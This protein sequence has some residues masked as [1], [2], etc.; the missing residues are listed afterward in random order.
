MSPNNIKVRI[1]PSPSGYLHVGTAR[2]AIFNWLYA[3]QHG[4]KFIVRIEDTD[5][6]RSDANLVQPILEALKWLGIDWDEGPYYQSER[7]ERY[8]AYVAKLL[9]SGRA[10]RCFCT[11]EELERERAEAMAKKMAPRYDRKCLKK[12]DAEIS[13]LLGKNMPFAIRLKIPQGETSYDDIVLGNITRQNSEIEDLVICRADGRVVYNMAV[14]VD[15]YEMG[16]THVIRGNDH[17]TNTFKQIHI[18]R[19]LGI[20]LP[21]FAHLPL[22]LRSDR[23]K[24]SK[25]LGDK[26]VSEYGKEG[27]LP[28]ALFNFLCLLGWSPKD[29][30]EFLSK[31]ELIRVFK[32]ENVNPANPIFNEEKLVAL[33]KEYIKEYQ[34]YKLAE[35]VAPLLVQ[36]GITTKYWLETRWEYLIKIIG[37]L[38]ER[39]RRMTDFVSLGKY[40]FYSEFNYEPESAQ[41]QFTAETKKYL[42]SL[43]TQFEEIEEFKKECLENA[44]NGLA[45]QLGI[46]KG[47]LIHPVRLAVSGISVGPGLYDILETLGKSEVLLRLQRAIKYI[48][49]N[50]G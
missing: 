10:Y 3:R 18:Y 39:C 42:I 14:V 44:L 49:N 35:M 1:A 19:G 11:P 5:E 17:V 45:E 15:D 12:T 4:G 23:K 25:R 28:E 22:I 43:L 40:F 46:K 48:E 30:R 38:K 20:E 2:T 41:K 50:G 13:E 27:I 32:L 7:M 29:N 33:N 26:D 16:I 47:Q 31:E 6:N 24:V 8:K 9:D 36:A 34:D 21:Q 37:L